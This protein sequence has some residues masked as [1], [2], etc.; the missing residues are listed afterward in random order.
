MRLSMENRQIHGRGYATH[1]TGYSS[2]GVHQTRNWELFFSAPG[3]ELDGQ[4]QSSSM[5]GGPTD[6]TGS[7]GLSSIDRPALCSPQPVDWSR[8][9]E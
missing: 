6:L 5:A 1:G 8:W 2:N 3:K 4:L 7:V 9:W